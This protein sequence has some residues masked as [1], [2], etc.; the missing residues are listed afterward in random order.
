MLKKI[1]IYFIFVLLFLLGKLCFM[2]F[3]A[4]IYQAYPLS[5]WMS[6]LYH[7]LPHDLTC[8][9][10]VMA[11]PFLIELFRIWFNGR[12]H[13]LFMR[14]YL[15][16]MVVLVL[17]N[18]L[19]DLV[20]Y[21]SWGFR[22]DGT[23]WFYLLDNPMEALGQGTL[24]QWIGGL[25]A[26]GLLSWCIQKPLT[27]FYQEKDRLHS[28]Y[29]GKLS[30]KQKS[31]HTLYSLLLCGVV[32]VA[33]R[34]GVTPST[35]NLGRVYF[36]TEMP[37]NHA[38]TNPLFSFFSTVGKQKRFDKQYR[39]MSAEEATTAFN[40]LH[41]TAA[42]D[43]IMGLNPDS[44]C[45][46][47]T[48]RP[49]IV[50]IV[51]EGFSG[52]ASRVL[53]PEIE[54]PSYMP[55]IDRFYEEGVGFSRFYANSF[56]TDRG[57]AALL[58]SYPGQPNNSVMKDQKKCNNLQYLSKR[59]KENGYRLR[60]VH[61]GDI[62]FT[63]MKGFLTAG[64]FT[65]I[66][67]D[68]DFPVADRL[69]K[70]GVPDHLMFNYLYDEIVSEPVGEETSPFFKCMLTLSSHEPF[71]VDYHHYE[72]PYLNSLAYADS[73]LGNFVDRLKA[74]PAWEN[75]LL[76]MVPDHCFSR[77]PE[78][79]NNH[80]ILRYHIPMVWVGGAVAGRRSID[81]LGQQTDLSA[82]LLSQMGIDHADFSFSKDLLNVHLPHYAFYAFSDG[83]GFLTD[84]CRYIQD[85]A[86]NG[87]ALSGS[88]DPNGTAEKWGKAYLQKL[89]D[90]L[91][92]R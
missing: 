17:I 14:G 59:L 22:I 71:D 10:Y 33:I 57:V 90:D 37:L 76:I 58:A 72:N 80:E 44:N 91:Q 87:C 8:A 41:A 89:Y 30:V 65:D 19:F 12:W 48:K 45:L 64:G 70:W 5:D 68:T 81:V 3:H 62:N 55:N 67:G 42:A 77:Y 73:C 4:D 21:G 82:T 47:T 27:L 35:M 9:G 28:G 83:F 85:N 50:L 79:L 60:F 16:I 49:N 11:L 20:L 25:L 38:A 40:Q 6:A 2:C 92:A 66:V 86:N 52:A 15:R 7:G 29:G 39:F 18:Y 56:R 53:H 69:S 34:G 46:L 24:L 74:T 61:G 43:T 78:T 13:T 26:L 31:L 84:S 1:A 75:L 51:L 63:N 54:D 32:F 23:A 36:S 88:E